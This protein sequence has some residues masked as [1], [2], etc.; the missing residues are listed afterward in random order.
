MNLPEFQ[1][2]ELNWPV[3]NYDYDQPKRAL[4]TAYREFIWARWI[5]P[6][7]LVRLQPDLLH[8]LNWNYLRNVGVPHV[9][10]LDDLSIVRFPE[11]FRKWTRLQTRSRLEQ[12]R[13]MDHLICISQFTADEAMDLLQIPASKI[14]VVHL[15]PGLDA[16]ESTP[17]SGTDPLPEAV[18]AEFLLFLGHLEPQKNLVLLRDVYDLADSTGKP[19]P[20]LVV[21]GRRWEGVT[22]E[23]APHKSWIYLGYQPDEVVSEL[24]QRA[25]LYVYPSR[26]EGFGMTILEAMGRRCPVVCTR[27]SSISEIGGEAPAYADQTAQD[28]FEVIHKVLTNDAFHNSLVRAGL[29]QASIFSWNRC[30]RETLA[31]YKMVLSKV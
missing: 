8:S 25:R 15:G 31:V 23:G 3:S 30:A 17:G 28:Y 11:R 19:L 26:Y 14:S 6:G 29:Q 4:K 18:P 7:Q 12:C 9:M 1:W 20:P 24:Y 27:V 5:A 2:E 22:S 13:K 16:T 21:V 10:T